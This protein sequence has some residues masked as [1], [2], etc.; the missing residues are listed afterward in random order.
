[1]SCDCGKHRFGDIN[2][3]IEL[4]QKQANI[5]NVIQYVYFNGTIYD[6]TPIEP[7]KYEK[8]IKPKKYYRKGKFIYEKRD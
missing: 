7:E 5:D 1:M 4:A 3:V 2:N 8:L 6:Y